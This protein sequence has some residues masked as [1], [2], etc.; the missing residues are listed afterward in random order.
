MNAARK[1]EKIWEEKRKAWEASPPGIYLRGISEIETGSEGGFFKLSEDDQKY[2]AVCLLDGEVYNGGFHQ[3]FFNS[4]GRYYLQ[5]LSG[6]LE[7]GAAQSAKI[8]REAKELL[9]GQGPVP[10]ETLS[11][12]SSLPEPDSTSMSLHTINRLSELDDLYCKPADA[13][14]NLLD[15]FAEEKCLY[16]SP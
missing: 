11:R 3:Y 8:L 10:Q 4:P 7:I 5:A 6:L 13:I 12:R 2:L 16:P 14:F 15:K 1:N 9:F